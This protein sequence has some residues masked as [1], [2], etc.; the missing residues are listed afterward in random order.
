M[1]PNPQEVERRKR[2]IALAKGILAVLVLILLLC[3]VAGAGVLIAYPDLAASF[4]QSVNAAM[5]VIQADPQKVIW[6][7]VLW[8]SGI[9][10]GLYLVLLG[11]ELSITVLLWMIRLLVA[12]ALPIVGVAVAFYLLHGM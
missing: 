10:I 5:A 2:E 11:S 12:L 7:G 9:L 4:G 6:I 8:G 3:I 1:V